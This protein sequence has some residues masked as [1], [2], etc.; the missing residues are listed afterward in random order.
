MWQDSRN[1]D[2]HNPTDIYMYDLSTSREI[3][4]TDDDSDQYSPDIYGDR[5]VWADWR[6]RGWDIYMYNIST[7]RETRITIDKGS[8][9]YPAIYGD[10]IAWVDSRIIILIFTYMIFP[11]MWKPGLLQTT[12]RN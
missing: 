6:N 8:Q 2:G 4:I 10:K 11:L 3:Q 9:E 5:I 1:G 7:S 12:Q